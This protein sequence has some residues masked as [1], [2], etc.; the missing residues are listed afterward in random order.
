ME[1]SLIQSVIAF[2][3]TTEISIKWITSYSDAVLAVSENGVTMRISV[4]CT[5]VLKKPILLIKDS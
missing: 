4:R 1:I 3:L 2:N 5:N